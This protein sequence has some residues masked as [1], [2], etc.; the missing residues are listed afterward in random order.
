MF[1]NAKRK[2]KEPWSWEKFR[3]TFSSSGHALSQNEIATL[4]IHAQP[5]IVSGECSAEHFA[6]CFDK[7]KGAI[8]SLSEAIATYQKPTRSL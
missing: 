3:E 5:Y 2:S 1:I 8:A 6:R 7:T 4:F